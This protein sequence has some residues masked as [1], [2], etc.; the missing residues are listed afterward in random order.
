MTTSRGADVL[1][2]VAK[3]LQWSAL[4]CWVYVALVSIITPRYLP[5]PFEGVLHIRT[6][7]LGAAAFGASTCLLIVTPLIGP[8]PASAR[9]PLRATWAVARSLALHATLG[10]AYISANSISH[11]ATLHL[12]LTHLVS[13][14][15]EGAFGFGCFLVAICSSCVYCGACHHLRGSL[16][17]MPGQSDGT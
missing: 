5:L 9:W 7:T 10:W 4:A 14:P 16:S 1:A 13:W 11:R 3:S 6:D 12:R 17:A 15:T 8:D 2:G